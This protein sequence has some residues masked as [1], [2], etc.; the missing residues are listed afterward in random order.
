MNQR[1]TAVND[2]DVYL[3]RIA[4]TIQK[5]DRGVPEYYLVSPIWHGVDR[6]DVGGTGCTN[7]TMARRL[8]RAIEAGAALGPAKVNVDVDGKTYVHAPHKFLAR[9]LNADLKKLGF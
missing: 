8:V 1:I 2:P 7:M 9:R 4:V 3:E 6:P 5:S